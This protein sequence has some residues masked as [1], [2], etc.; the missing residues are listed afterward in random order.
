MLN[1]SRFDFPYLLNTP[2]SERRS[3]LMA[4]KQIETGKLPNYPKF[5]IKFPSSGPAGIQLVEPQHKL[6]LKLATT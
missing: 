2:G 6:S 4:G 3:V 1:Y 5:E